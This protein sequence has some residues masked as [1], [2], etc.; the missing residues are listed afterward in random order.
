M[1]G[2]RKRSVKG[3]RKDPPSASPCHNISLAKIR[4]NTCH[5]KPGKLFSSKKF[6]RMLENTTNLFQKYSSA[7]T[8]NPARLPRERHGLPHAPCAWLRQLPGSY[9]ETRLVHLVLH[10]A[11]AKPAL[12]FKHLGKD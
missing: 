1:T 12:V 2:Q 11:R 10:I 7:R 3:L 8:N 5:K 6:S 9:M 4:Q